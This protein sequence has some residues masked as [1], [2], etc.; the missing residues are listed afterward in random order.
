MNVITDKRLLESQRM[1]LQD[2]KMTKLEY[3]IANINPPT[4]A[5]QYKGEKAQMY[6]ITSQVLSQALARGEPYYFFQLSHSSQVLT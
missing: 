3:Y 1:R 4:L 2:S 5:P 6:P